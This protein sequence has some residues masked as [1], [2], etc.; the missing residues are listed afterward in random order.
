MFETTNQCIFE[1]WLATSAMKITRA[2]GGFFNISSPSRSNLGR[3][4]FSG[5]E[6]GDGSLVWWISLS[7]YQGDL[8]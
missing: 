5:L 4:Q 8:E 6:L 3:S 1:C 2:V 7:F